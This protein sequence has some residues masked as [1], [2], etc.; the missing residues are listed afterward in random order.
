LLNGARPWKLEDRVRLLL[1]YYLCMDS[2]A[3]E[4][5][6]EYEAA[7]DAAGADLSPLLYLKNMKA[8]T[9]MT[10]S[11]GGV[12]ASSGTADSWLSK[13]VSGNLTGLVKNLI[14]IGE[15]LA[16]TRLVS[17]I[18]EQRATP[19]ADA[20]V[21]LDPKVRRETA[22]VTSPYTEAIVF[23]VGG[24]SYTEYQNLQ[25]NIANKSGGPKRTL[26]YGA[27]EICNAE[28]FLDQ[29]GKLGRQ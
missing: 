21:Y 12:Q 3:A 20:F 6:A 7:L 16:T 27:T 9:S 17:A 2:I 15:E 29:L 14:P 23:V 22:R 24:G 18:V 19:E 26:I 5:L 13:V 1:V 10:A 11:T 25:D 8:M 4:E 28:S